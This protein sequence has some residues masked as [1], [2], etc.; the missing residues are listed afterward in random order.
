MYLLSMKGYSAFFF[1]RSYLQTLLTSDA[2][3][4]ASRR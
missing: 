4:P 3:F 1:S 2:E